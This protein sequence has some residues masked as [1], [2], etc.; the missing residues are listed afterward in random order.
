MLEN[1]AWEGLEWGEVRRCCKVGV[2]GVSCSV[3]QTLNSDNHLGWDGGEINM[4]LIICTFPGHF[5]DLC[6]LHLLHI[7]FL[8]LCKLFLLCFLFIIGLEGVFG[9]VSELANYFVG[10]EAIN[11]F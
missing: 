9:V 5:P 8:M 11:I 7:P 1:I 4:H 3:P 6:L 2:V 10:E